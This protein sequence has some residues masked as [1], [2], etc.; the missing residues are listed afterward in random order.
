[1]PL[2]AGDVS[3]ATAR[4]CFATHAVLTRVCKADVPRAGGLAAFMLL[5]VGDV[6]A[7]RLFTDHSG[8][9]ASRPQTGQELPP[10]TEMHSVHSR[11]LCDELT[12]MYGN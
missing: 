10:V 2:L 6:F 1:M 9:A 11:F 3:R 4:R 12:H 8:G 5:H 7:S